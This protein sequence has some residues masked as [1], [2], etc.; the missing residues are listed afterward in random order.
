[1]E[2]LLYQTGRGDNSVEDLLY[3]Y[4]TGRGDIKST[5]KKKDCAKCGKLFARIDSLKRH[6]KTCLG[7]ENSKC[8]HCNAPFKG[9]KCKDKHEA[10]CQQKKETRCQHC[11]KFFVIIMRYVRM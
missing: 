5:E 2:D 10:V 9:L 4:Q 7:V 1:M 6:K 11:A 8:K 3:P